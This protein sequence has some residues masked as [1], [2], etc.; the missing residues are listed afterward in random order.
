LAFSLSK[1]VG[2]VL[3]IFYAF[4]QGG[5]D[6]KDKVRRGGRASKQAY[7]GA[8]GTEPPVRF[9]GSCLPGSAAATKMAPIC[10]KSNV[11]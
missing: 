10:M 5:M 8:V 2:D 11:S 7:V 4:L 9:H 1:A 3:R 6:I